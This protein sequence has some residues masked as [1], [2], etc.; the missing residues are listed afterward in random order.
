MSTFYRF[1]SAIFKLHNYKLCMVGLDN[2][3]KTT[4]LFKL[5]LGEVVNT[6]PTIGSNVEEVIYK[7]IHLHIWDLGGQESIRSSWSTYYFD[8]QG[9]VM[10]VDSTDE[11]RLPIVKQELDRLI[12]SEELSKA[13]IL[14]YANKIDLEPR[15]EVAEIAQRLG[16][17]NIKSHAWHIQPCSAIKGMGLEDG[18]AWLSKKLTS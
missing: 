17:H 5:H 3:G 6:Q 11:K 16:L 4:T 12:A 18:I 7:N 1:Y 9:I 2:A 15:M 8:A 14:V 13:V 10:V